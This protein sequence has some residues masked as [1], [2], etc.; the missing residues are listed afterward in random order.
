[1]DNNKL[2]VTAAPHITSTDTTETSINDW[3]FSIVEDFNSLV[4][5]SLV[6][7]WR[8]KFALVGA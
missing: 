3:A 1:M 6:E 2:I 8:D 4:N 7:G 5:L